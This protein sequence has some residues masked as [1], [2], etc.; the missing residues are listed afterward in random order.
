M[1][2]SNESC[3]STTEYAGHVPTNELPRPRSWSELSTQQL[4]VAYVATSM[5]AKMQSESFYMK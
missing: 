1:E 5:D 3:T 4:L 2:G